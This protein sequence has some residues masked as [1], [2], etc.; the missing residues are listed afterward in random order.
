MVEIAGD[1]QTDLNAGHVLPTTRESGRAARRPRVAVAL[2]I[3]ALSQALL[4]LLWVIW[5]VGRAGL[6]TVFVVSMVVVSLVAQRRVDGIAR[7]IWSVI[8]CFWAG[9]AFWLASTPLTLQSKPPARA[10]AYPMLNLPQGFEAAFDL[11][12][13]VTTAMAIGAI[14]GALGWA[15]WAV[16]SARSDN[17]WVASIAG[18]ATAAP[19]TVELA[20]GNVDSIAGSTYGGSAAN[21]APAVDE[22]SSAAVRVDSSAAPRPALG[23]EELERAWGPP[24]SD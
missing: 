22:A 1:A 14:C 8:S 13:I 19:M 2:A 12:P 11:L 23:P 6:T 16:L 20:V 4:A 10:L 3:G 9:F 18:A 21:S 7:L 17:P 5:G 15:R 24:T